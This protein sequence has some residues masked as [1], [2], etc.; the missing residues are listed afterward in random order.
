MLD[1]KE[2][3]LKYDSIQLLYIR[4][5]SFVIS[6]LRVFRFGNWDFGI[7]I[8]LLDSVRFVLRAAS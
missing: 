1:G 3:I 4:Q 5:S 8:E 6:G 2:L 7:W